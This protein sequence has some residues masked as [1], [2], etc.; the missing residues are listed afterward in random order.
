MVTLFYLNVGH[1]RLEH[2]C[3]DHHIPLGG[4]EAM[5]CMCW[6]CYNAGLSSAGYDKEIDSRAQLTKS[7]LQAFNSEQKTDHVING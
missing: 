7:I 5:R 4:G 2:L 6:E 1:G 3:K